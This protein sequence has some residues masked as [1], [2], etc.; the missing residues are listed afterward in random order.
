MILIKNMYVIK[1]IGLIWQKFPRNRKLTGRND[2]KFILATISTSFLNQ[3]KFDLT[4]ET[5]FSW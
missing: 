4:Y 2:R 3:F 1:V 5:Y